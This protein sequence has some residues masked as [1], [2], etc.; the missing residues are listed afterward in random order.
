[1]ASG[2]KA[3]RGAA[4]GRRRTGTGKARSP[5]LRAHL[6]EVA[7][8]LLVGAALLVLL[9]LVSY[10]AFDPSGNTVAPPDAEYRNLVGWLGAGIA[11]WLVQGLGIGAYAAVALAILAAW[12]LVFRRSEGLRLVELASWALI[13]LS[14]LTLAPLLVPQ[15]D[16][17]GQEA[18]TG[19]LIGHFL[20]EALKARLN[21]AGA[22][23][24]GSV[25]LLVTI[26][27]GLDLSF[28]PAGA[29]IGRF[30]SSAGQGLTTG[31]VRLGRAGSDGAASALS[32]FGRAGGT[33]AEDARGWWAERARR[34][35][36]RAARTASIPEKVPPP[37]RH[38]SPGRGEAIA[39][40]PPLTPRVEP[41]PA[42]AIDGTPPALLA[43]DLT[44]EVRLDH[45]PAPAR[46]A[47]PPPPEPG[48]APEP[49][50]PPLGPPAPSVKAKIV[51]SR[52]ME[53]GGAADAEQL[54]LPL[55]RHGHAF[56]IPSLSLLD[57]PVRSRLSL[58]E[59]QLQDRATLLEQKLLDYGVEGQVVE[60]HPGPVVT[61]F[62]F[63]PAPGI[64][65]SRIANLS[66]DLSMA[67]KATRVRIVAPLPGKGVVGIE[68]PNEHR[69]T[70]Y[71]R[72]IMAHEEFHGR[73][74]QL[75]IAFGKDIV[76]KPTAADWA[77]MPHL[78]IAGTTGS[79]KSVSVNSIILSIVCSRTP[80]EV[81]MILVD[82]KMLE[83]SLYDG[84]PHLLLP[85]VTSPKKAAMALKWAVEEMARRYRLLAQLET[86]NIVGYNQR[87]E[88]LDKM[89]LEVGVAEALK[90]L[91]VEER[92]QKLPYIVI[93]IDELADL[94]MVAAKDVQDSIVRLAQMARAAGIH[95]LLATQRPSVDVITGLIKAN[96]PARV[97]FRVSSKIDSRT[98]LDCNGAEHL[99]GQGDML[100]LLPGKGE[101]KRIHG[102]FVSDDEV[103]RV[104]THLKAQA[105]PQYLDSILEA[106][107]ASEDDGDEAEEL[108]EYYDQAVA[109]VA[110]TRAASTS[111]L[112]RRLKI[113]YN[114]AA[115]IIE[116]MEKE[117]VVGPADG[118][119]PREVFVQPFD[120][121]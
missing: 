108:D 109:V 121:E 93:I 67:L 36:A 98:I 35:E 110:E 65:V 120:F 6:K 88:Q 41:P 102:A 80:D 106:K 113:G 25:S 69:E 18:R 73:G 7:A 14:F 19:G 60:I 39:A 107:D 115:R 26:K 20:S 81:R 33:L 13:G 49:A 114:R 111:M 77:K 55:T 31:L 57:P 12:R 9:S 87:V 16:L 21:V 105:E 30:T 40:A 5:A 10:D 56:E 48:D 70:V 104:V 53:D 61:M 27:L 37:V 78:L 38:P 101:L 90:G 42:R 17:G 34:R 83:F 45:L 94:M 52:H 74:Y 47:G 68:V 92:P 91:P 64:K 2:G 15:V 66:D 62:E 24:V 75:P 79:G 23:V 89:A 59:Q 117:G 118:A 51:L 119:K 46:G 97:S 32:A 84:I 96:F 1:M 54:R 116:R 22:I 28:A 103:K 43:P 112:Q 82:P 71:L 95:L 8:I 72:E 58:D 86:R 3:K 76:G 85:V 99:L 44:D 29:W 100:F 50:P 4:N 11:D 63:E